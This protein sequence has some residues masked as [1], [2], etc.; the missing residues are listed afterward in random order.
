MSP[1]RKFYWK[2][3][4]GMRRRR[5]IPFNKE[6]RT[7]SLIS[8]QRNLS[9]SLPFVWH[10][11][12][13]RGWIESSHQPVSVKEGGKLKKRMNVTEVT[14]SRWKIEGNSS[15]LSHRT[16]DR[17]PNLSGKQSSMSHLLRNRQTRSEKNRPSFYTPVTSCYLSPFLPVCLSV[18]CIMR[19]ILVSMSTSFIKRFW[20]KVKTLLNDATN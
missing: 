15:P 17:P 5:D 20:S 4:Q 1:K 11:P 10:H 18:V 14:L 2:G 19:D 13:T 7:D 3:R 12:H 6:S 16:S 8:F 9:V